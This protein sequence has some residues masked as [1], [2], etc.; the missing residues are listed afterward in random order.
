MKKILKVD[1]DLFPQDIA[2][3]LGNANCIEQGVILHLLSNAHN[4]HPHEFN[5]QVMAVRDQIKQGY[6]HKGQNNIKSMIKDMYEIL[7]EV[8]DGS[9]D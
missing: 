7:C 8:K 5:E 1:I 4:C 9:D 6:D 2:E 3:Y